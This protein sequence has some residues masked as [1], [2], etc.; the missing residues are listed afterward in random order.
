MSQQKFECYE[1]REDGI[2]MY[3]RKVYVLNDQ[4]F[5]SMILSEMHKVPYVGPPSYQ[6]TIVSVKK[7]YF[8]PC[9]K[10]EVANFIA[11][12]LECQKVKVEN[13]HPYGFLKLLP[14]SELKWE[15]VTT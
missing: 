11:K 12:C 4:E 1:L 6:K 8:W 5:K 10:K 2:L 7:Q 15:F 14:I 13:R 3:R 9:M